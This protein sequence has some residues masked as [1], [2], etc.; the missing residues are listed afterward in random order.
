MIGKIE[1]INTYVIKRLYLYGLLMKFKL[2]LTVVFSSVMAYLFCSHDANIISTVLLAISGFSITASANIFNQII[3]RN[4]DKLMTRTQNRPLPQNHLTLI[5]A[6]MLAGILGV[7]G[8]GLLSSYFNLL[9][10][11]LGALALLSYAFIYTPMKQ[12]SPVSVFIGAIPGAMPLIIGSVAATNAV[13]TNGIILFAIQFLWQLPHFW[14]IA[15]LLDSDYKKAGFRL[16]PTPDGEKSRSAA[17]QCLPYL[18]VL[19][20]V[21]TLP[22]LLGYAGVVSL[23]IGLAA[24]LFYLLRGFDFVIHLDDASAKKLMFT[25]FGYIPVVLLS[26][27]LDKI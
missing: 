23:L 16:L 7:I 27:V 22:Y 26:Y 3:E 2:S 5:E 24:S 18:L 21:S 19:V 6:Y 1:N 14:S 13:T 11:I 20:V 9:S 10:G 25:S 15:W 17:V 8:I 4:E 12:L